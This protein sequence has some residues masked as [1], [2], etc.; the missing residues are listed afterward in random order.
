MT[1]TTFSPPPARAFFSLALGKQREGSRSGM[2]LL[3]VFFLILSLGSG[4]FL[5]Y[6]HRAEQ[7]SH[8][9]Q[10]LSAAL[11]DSESVL[12]SLAVMEENGR[13]P[14]T[15]AHLT[16]FRAYRIQAISALADIGQRPSTLTAKVHPVYALLLSLFS[17][18]AYSQGQPPPASSQ[19]VV[20]PAIESRMIG[21]AVSLGRAFRV[22][23]KQ[24]Q[25]HQSLMRHRQSLAALS[26]GFGLV[27][28]FV[29][30]AALWRH[31]MALLR[32]RARQEFFARMSHELRTPLN[33]ITGYSQL[34]LSGGDRD[35]EAG[36]D[37]EK[38]L[39]ASR[40]LEALIDD[41]FDMAKIGNRKLRL[42][43]GPF[44]I[45]EL[46]EEA[47]DMLRPSIEGSGNRLAVDRIPLEGP[48][49]TDR[50]RVRQI[51]INLLEN[52]RKFT[53]HGEIRISSSPDPEIPHFFR[54]TVSDTGIGMTPDQT[55]RIFEPFTQADENTR[56]R[57]G[58]TGLGLAISR[59]LARLMGGTMS[60]ESH[61]AKGS[62][63]TLRLPREMPSQETRPSPSLR[64]EPEP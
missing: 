3:V 14:L 21:L 39:I 1:E 22:E 48:V 28:S 50:R 52:A 63:F 29:I 16:L 23:E 15:P 31:E 54:V 5:M 25:A 35:S 13:P 56:R 47:A 55:S 45:E 60:V 46:V 4:A 33:A 62:T 43:P 17:Y 57:Y 2:I 10:K 42:E 40:H 26:S 58:G 59:S 12:T 8:L 6:G 32:E 11:S 30:A 64:K 24:L 44:L 20:P 7:D 61:P 38:I 9:Q 19:E 34:I 51:L 36:Q 53:D 41:L 18:T 49:V 27:L 37:A